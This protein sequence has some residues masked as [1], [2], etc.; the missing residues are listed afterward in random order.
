MQAFETIAT[1]LPAPFREAAQGVAEDM[2]VRTQEIR[3]RLGMPLTLSTPQGDWYVD[4]LGHCTRESV[5]GPL[6]R[7]DQL[8][9]CFQRL[10]EYSVHTHQQ[11][12]R[13][14]Y[15]SLRGGGRAGLAGSVVTQAGEIVTMRRISSLCLRVA[16]RHEG[17]AAPLLR[18]LI[19]CGDVPST[20]IVG[21]PSSGK[22]SLLRD[23]ARQLA[24]GAAGRRY[25]VAVVDERG[26]LAGPGGLTGCDVLLH[27]PKG[28]GIQQ[29]VRSLAP[30][31]ILFDEIGTV[32]EADAVLAGLNA[33][34]AAI[35]TAHARDLAALRRR[36]PIYAALAGG[37]FGR[38]VLL[39]GRSR[40]GEI[41]MIREVEEWL[42]ED[43]RTAFDCGGR[44]TDGIVCRYGA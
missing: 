11:E 35:A 25:R 36:P 40:P 14:G 22:S 39:K 13:E 31:V 28:Q 27:C 34:V 23:L 38:L 42:H 17:C 29:A 20:L 44:D 30:D 8:D 41:A 37:A 15:I 3:L 26:E 21:E 6:C 33:G 9:E 4:G 10:C 2:Q 5:T 1:Y 43:R 24:V 32:E 12:I 19:G 16:R 18:Q 7:D